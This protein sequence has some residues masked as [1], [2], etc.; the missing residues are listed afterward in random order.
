MGASRQ[1][2]DYVILVE[3]GPNFKDVLEKLADN[4]GRGYNL[5][6]SLAELKK[7]MQELEESPGTDLNVK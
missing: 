5:V 6:E 4:A 7:I 2:Y 3:I 1:D